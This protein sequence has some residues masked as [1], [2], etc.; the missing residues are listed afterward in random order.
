MVRYVSR[1]GSHLISHGILQNIVRLARRSW[2]N[3]L[4]KRSLRAPCEQLAHLATNPLRHG[5]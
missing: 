5:G 2:E 4:P 3:L 1:K